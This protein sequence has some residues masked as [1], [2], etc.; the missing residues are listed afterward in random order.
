MMVC[1]CN[2]GDDKLSDEGKDIEN[3]HGQQKIMEP[4]SEF[5]AVVDNAAAGSTS[6][7]E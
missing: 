6:S 4:I 1:A 5:T 2:S 3:E 7:E